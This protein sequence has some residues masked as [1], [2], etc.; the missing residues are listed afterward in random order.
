MFFREQEWRENELF[1][2]MREIA[3]AAIDAYI[4]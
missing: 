4:Y 3:E 2:E 1:K